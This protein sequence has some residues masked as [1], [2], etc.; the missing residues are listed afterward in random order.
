MIALEG[1][2]ILWKLESKS[3]NTFNDPGREVEG[4]STIT[5]SEPQF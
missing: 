4:P 5:W 2:K 1:I 3:H